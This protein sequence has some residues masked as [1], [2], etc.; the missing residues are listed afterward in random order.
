MAVATVTLE[1]QVQE[2][3]FPPPL[4]GFITPFSAAKIRARKQLDGISD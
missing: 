3:D 4:G 1:S 2:I